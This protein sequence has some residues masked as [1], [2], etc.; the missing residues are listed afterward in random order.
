MDFPYP[1]INFGLPKVQHLCKMSILYLF[2]PARS[3]IV[4]ASLRM[5][6]RRAWINTIDSSPLALSFDINP[7]TSKIAESPRWHIGVGDDVG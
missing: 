1:I 5:R 3:A 6:Y 2:T 4:H 7:A